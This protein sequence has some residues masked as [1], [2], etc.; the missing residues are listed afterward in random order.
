M[1]DVE[2]QDFE[3]FVCLALCKYAVDRVAFDRRA[4]VGSVHDAHSNVDLTFLPS[5]MCLL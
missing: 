3:T 5:S 1:F 2:L 4:S